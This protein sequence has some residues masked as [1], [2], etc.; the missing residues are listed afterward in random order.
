MSTSSV[1]LGVPAN[2]MF[3]NVD[4]QEASDG[5]VEYRCIFILNDHA[6][7]T[8][9]APYVWLETEVAGGADIS[10]GLDPAGVVPRGQASAQAAEIATEDDAPAGVSFSAPTSKG[11]GLSVSNIP[12]DYCQAVWVRR[13]VDPGTAAKAGD[14]VTIRVEGDSPA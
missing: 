5:D 11:T 14:G 10:I 8:F 6:T 2:S 9:I 4:G 13:T 7:I 12:P 3:D 1:D